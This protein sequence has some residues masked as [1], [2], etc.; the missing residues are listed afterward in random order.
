MLAPSLSARTPPAARRG[1]L[2]ASCSAHL[3]HLAFLS[4]AHAYG[5]QSAKRSDPLV[6]ILGPLTLAGCLTPPREV[7]GNAC[8]L[9]FEP[10]HVTDDP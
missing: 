1:L 7:C 6:R 4:P 2:L 8:V 5:R 10:I 9:A 3:L